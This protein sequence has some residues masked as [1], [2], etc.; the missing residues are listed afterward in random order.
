VSHILIVDDEDTNLDLFSRRLRRNG[1]TV[2]IA[3]S[4]FQALELIERTHFDLVLLDQMMPGMSGSEVLTT[5]RKRH[6]FLGLPIIMVTAVAEPSQIA[7]SLDMGASDYI[8]K[9]IEFTVALARIRSHLARREA[10]NELLRSEERYELAARGSSD[11]LW[12]WDLKRNEIYYSPRWKALLG[13][14][15]EFDPSPEPETW[16]S[17]VHPRDR[18]GLEQAIRAHLDDQSPSLEAEYRIRHLDGSYRWMSVRGLA[19]RSNEGEAYRI[20]GSQSDVT[21]EKTIDALTGLS[22]RVLFSDRLATALERI[23][24]NPLRKFAILFLDLDRFKL[25]NDSLGHQVGDA[26]LVQVAQRLRASLRF[27]VTS[28]QVCSDTVVARIGGDEFGIL[29]EDIPDQSAAEGIADRVLEAMR[30]A[31][32][33]KTGKIY[34]AVTIGIAL[35]NSAH[36]SEE[37]LLQDADTAMSVAKSRGKA[38]WAVFDSSMHERQR[39]RLQMETDLRLAVQNSEFEVYYQPRVQLATGDVCGFEALVRWNHPILGLVQ[40]FEFIPVA[41][42]SGLIHEI[43]MWVLRE[44]CRQTHAWNAACSRQKPLD[45]AVNLSARQ[46]KVPSLIEEVKDILR[47]TGLP[48]ALLNLELTESILVQDLDATRG[49]LNA[50]KKIGLGLKLDDFGTGFS[51]LKV[52]AELPFDTIKIDRSFVMSMDNRSQDSTEMVRTIMRM[53]E[54]LKMGVIAEGIET[55]EHA[56]ILLSMGCQFGQGFYYSRPVSATASLALLEK[57]N[58]AGRTIAKVQV[59]GNSATEEVSK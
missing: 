15:E 57:S 41:E 16:F 54:S 4:G 35:P 21:G 22:N 44:A 10:E 8:T 52:L 39:S 59:E 51:S 6:S 9:P 55:P 48:P 19:V 30:P 34:V 13:W 37:E 11:G 26:V 20:A 42:E 25:I 2:E 43:G 49:V 12:D 38:S 1:F 3:V 47:E 28:P 58:G 24:S 56:K 32:V 27:P 29:V 18:A 23:R 45:I 5:L 33:L 31:F 53:A 46:C 40:P 14:G 7:A 50:L 36:L 17:R